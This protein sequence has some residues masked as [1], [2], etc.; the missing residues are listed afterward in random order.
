MVPF[1][2]ADSLLC[3]NMLIFVV[4][5]ALLKILFVVF[6]EVL[7]V[8]MVFAEVVMVVVLVVILELAVV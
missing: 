5:A 7:V 2:H 1:V 4:E 8:L 3:V 6:A